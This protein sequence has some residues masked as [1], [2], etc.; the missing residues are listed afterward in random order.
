MEG[1]FYRVDVTE[2]IS[3]LALD[4]LYWGINNVTKDQ[5]DAP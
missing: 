4:T 1:G 2:K 3:V 5:G